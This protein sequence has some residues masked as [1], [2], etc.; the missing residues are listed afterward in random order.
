[1]TAGHPNMG[2]PKEGGEPLPH[3]QD[4]LNPVEAMGHSLL[5]F[6]AKTFF[7]IEHKS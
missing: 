1:M 6:F 2:K 3:K 5:S 7:I 4:L